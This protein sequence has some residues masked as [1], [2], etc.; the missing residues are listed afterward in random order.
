MS[1]QKKRNKKVLPNTHTQTN[2]MEFILCCPTT[3]GCGARTGGNRFIFFQLVSIWV[4]SGLDLGSCVHFPLSVLELHLA[5]TCAVMHATIVSISSSVHNSSCV[6]T[7]LF[8][9]SYPSPL[10][11]IVFLPP[12]L[13]RCLS[14]E[15]RDL[16][17]ISHLGLSTP[18]LLVALHN[19]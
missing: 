3:L 14:P 15:E 2:P 1:K 19:L 18:R 6:L 12:L 13:N 4:T 17:N 5:W 7:T 9:W 10:A 16:I 11:F 8:P